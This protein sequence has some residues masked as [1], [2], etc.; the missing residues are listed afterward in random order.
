MIV[1]NFLVP[2]GSDLRLVIIIFSN[3]LLLS[4]MGCRII[5][6]MRKASERGLNAGTSCEITVGIS[7]TVLVEVPPDTPGQ[8]L[9]EIS[10]ETP[11]QDSK[12]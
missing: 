3:P 11:G 5:L 1:I 8:V 2:I 9:V 7:T 4:P 6:N 10:P 12:C